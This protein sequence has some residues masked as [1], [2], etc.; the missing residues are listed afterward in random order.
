MPS[1]RRAVL[2]RASLLFRSAFAGALLCSIGCSVAVLDDAASEE[3]INECQDQGDCA[4]GLCV[5]GRCQARQGFFSTILVE[6]SPPASG[7]PA[8]AGVS[9]LHRLD[10]LK[11]EGEQREIRLAQTAKVTG[12]VKF[13][14]YVVGT[15]GETCP[16][17]FGA[18]QP[19]LSVLADPAGIPAAVS[20]TPSDRI[21]GVASTKYNAEVDISGLADVEPQQADP[22]SFDIDLPP[23]DYDIYIR[24][25]APTANGCAIPP[26]LLRRFN[27]Q[28]SELML[29]LPLP[30]SATFALTINMP[31]GT[32]TSLKGWT[33]DMLD[34]HTGLVISTQSVLGA[35][36]IGTHVQYETQIAYSPVTLREG[37]SEFVRLAPPQGVDAPTIVLDRSGLS[38]FTQG[39]G[40]IE[41]FSGYPEPVT[42]EGQLTLAGVAEPT[43]GTVTVVSTSLEGV[44]DGV[45]ASFVRSAE[46]DDDGNFTMNLLP[47]K[48]HV[49]AWPASSAVSTSAASQTEWEIS[50]E[51]ALQAGKTVELL[52][53]AHVTGIAYLPVQGE[54]ATGAS[55]TAIASPRDVQ[56]DLLTR[57]AQ[58]NLATAPAA[59]N[60][61]VDGDGFF[62]VQ[63]DP[64][65]FDISVR[66]PVGSGFAWYVA[67]QVHV[68]PAATP[69]LMEQRL[70]SYNL[71][72]P[73]P[74]SGKVVWSSGTDSLPI[75]EALLRAYVYL[76]EN[77]AYTGDPT[78]AAAVVQI[79]ETRADA[80]GN[81]E[82]LIPA[83]LN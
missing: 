10:A 21:L 12:T 73:V 48:Y 70:G 50:A 4:T 41:E 36:S 28:P 22:L 80:D 64:G 66:P 71:P 15:E 49:Y 27:V 46:V 29:N 37:E 60:A 58:G 67:S 30:P 1:F 81:F 55:V 75:G 16:L 54:P 2:Q 83:N 11:L 7:D 63:A 31:A 52:P 47:G 76:D 79:G 14:P 74:Y 72:L 68:Q 51:P 42:V 57:A 65:V 45:F 40:V 62:D 82:L 32:K 53:P 17:S 34:P 3:A 69:E 43:P 38:I 20:F 25:R 23:G 35:P 39:A 19:G 59:Q 77:N 61:V 26:T 78:R 44:G 8:F 18:D 24:P 9:Y 33:V 5:D 6:V 56:V 13:D